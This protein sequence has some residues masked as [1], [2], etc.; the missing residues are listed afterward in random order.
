MG[1]TLSLG[2]FTFQEMEIPEVVPFHGAQR[3]SV[4]KLIGG[5]RVIDAMGTDPQPI[6][7]SGIF[8]PTNDGESPLDRARLVEAIREAGQPVTLQW[9]ALNLTVFVSEFSPDYRFARI[10]YSITVEVLQDNTRS[11]SKTPNPTADDL[12]G[13]DLSAANVIV[14]SIGDATL[15]TQ[16]AS[17]TSL[18]FAASSVIALASSA[19]AGTGSVTTLV[20]APLSTTVPIQQQIAAAQLRVA[21]LSVIQ[22]ATLNTPAGPG[23]VSAGASPSVNIEAFEA[24]EAATQQQVY[25]VQLAC[26]LGRMNL[27]LG[28][29]NSSER[30]ITVSGG[31]LYD[32]AAREY[33]DSTAADQIMQ[34]NDLNDPTLT[35]NVT[36][37]IPPYNPGQAN[38]GVG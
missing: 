3:L 17:L 7:W 36:L 1:I 20:G 12:V 24:L 27:N 19:S 25:L 6:T 32:V 29:I 35:G 11:V 28:Q 21:A 14:P 34:A 16:M 30:T 13:A 18:V 8:F 38:G 4:K 22:D 9:D 23:G 37:A 5:T 26:L 31:N 2:T 10:P 15:T 33:G